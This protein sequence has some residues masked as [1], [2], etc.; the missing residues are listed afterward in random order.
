[1]YAFIFSEQYFNRKAM[2]IASAEYKRICDETKIILKIFFDAG[3]IKAEEKDLKDIAVVFTSLMFTQLDIYISQ[4]KEIIRQ[5]PDAGVGSLF[6][7][8]TDESMLNK[9]MKVIMTYLESVL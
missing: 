7:L 2:E 1:M 3:T 8:P 9:C 4:K 6:A 5:N